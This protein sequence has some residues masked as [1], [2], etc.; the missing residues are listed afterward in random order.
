MDKMT[1]EVSLDA[2]I[3]DQLRLRAGRRGVSVSELAKAY[4][5]DWVDADLG[6]FSR[7]AIYREHTTT[8]EERLGRSQPQS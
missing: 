5:E 3:A 6:P 4:I 2:D 1:V 7:K 8:L